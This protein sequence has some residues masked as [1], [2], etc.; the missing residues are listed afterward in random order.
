GGGRLAHGPRAVPGGP[1]RPVHPSARH[2]GVGFGL[3]RAAV[4]AWR[5]ER[6]ILARPLPELQDH[7]P[8]PGRELRAGRGRARGIPRGRLS[9]VHPGR[10]A[11]PGGTGARRDGLRTGPEGGEVP[12]LL[13]EWVT[14]QPERQTVVTAGGDNA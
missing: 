1:S 13:Q 14:L 9:H 10:A 7:V 12:E 2:E 11:G 3:A 5:G 4:R 8:V 6:T